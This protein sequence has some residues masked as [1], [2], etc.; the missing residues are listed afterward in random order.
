[1]TF[2][3]LHDRA[4]HVAA[5]LADLGIDSTARVSWQLPTWI[6]S[7]VLV[8]ALSRLGALQNP[9]LPIYRE[10]E[11]RYILREV[12]PQLL[13]TPGVWRGFDHA[14]LAA[15]VVDELRESDDLV[16]TTLVCDHELP[17]GDPATLPPPPDDPDATRWVFYTSG[18]T[19]D[20]KGA[21][22]SDATITA[23]A[24]GIVRGFA[25]RR[26]GS[27]SGRL[28]VH[29]HRRRRHADR[30]APLRCWS[31]RGRALRS[32]GDASPARG[33]R[34]HDRG[35]RHAARAAVPAVPA[36]APRAVGVPE[37]PRHDDGRCAQA[38]GTA[39]RAAQRARRD[40][41]GIGLRPDRGAVP[42]LQ[43]GA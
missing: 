41:R 36:G 6:E 34:A 1:M 37:G 35:G 28:P 38:T 7:F 22:H 9:M 10:R 30:P 2:A 21:R 12:R 23:G 27:L 14:G 39:R 31:D 16:C 20:P 33:A 40:R 5:G 17:T 18:T 15:K 24:E 3:E 4:E 8:A 25:V 11:I 13:I 26:G 19:A 32:R 43:L 42:R 29:A